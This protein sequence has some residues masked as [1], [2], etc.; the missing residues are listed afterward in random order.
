MQSDGRSIGGLTILRSRFI[1]IAALLFQALW[2]NV[3]VPGHQRGAVAL[4]GETCPACQADADAC[5][6]EM[7]EPPPVHPS[8]PAPGDPASHCAIC[9]FAA[10]LFNPPAIDFSPPAL[11]LLESIKPAVWERATAIRFDPTYD[12]RAPPAPSFQFV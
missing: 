12:G 7:A 11:E 5:C 6:P 3:I 10:A 4:P 8:A 1:R 2:L 9:H